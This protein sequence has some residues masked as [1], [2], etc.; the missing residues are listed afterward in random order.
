MPTPLS[1]RTREVI[2][3]VNPAV[4]GTVN[5]DG[6]PQTSVVWVGRDGDDLLIS[7]EAGRRKVLNLERDPRASL[8]VYDKNDP[9]LYVEVRGATTITEDQGRA[10][11][12]ELAERFEGPGTGQEYLDL[13]PEITRV[14]IRLTPHK[15]VGTA[16]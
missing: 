6:S 4:L 3:G 14:V 5:P 2:D 10:L 13:P 15:V 12:V 1:A 7:T 16:T 9:E 8:I 11:A